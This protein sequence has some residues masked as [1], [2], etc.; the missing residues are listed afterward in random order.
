[1]PRA[2]APFI[3]RA[4]LGVATAILCSLSSAAGAQEANLPPGWVPSTPAGMIAEPSLLR[5]LASASESTIGGEP[6]DGFYVETGNMI[7]GE[8]W[9][10]AGPGYR[11]HLLDGAAVIDG[12]AAVSWNLYRTAQVSLQFPHLA[13]DRLSI[14]GQTM[15][16]DVLQVEYFGL[17]NDSNKSDQT[18][19]R[20]NN[21]DVVAF[22]RVQAN[23]WLSLDGRIGW[24]PRPDLSTATGPRV[25][26]PNTTDRF[27]EA[28]AP[29]IRTQPSFVHSDVAVVADTRDHAGHP[30]VGGLYRAS[31]AIYSDRGQGT[32]SFRRYE[33]EASQFVPLFT[34]KW[35]LALHGWEV[36]SDT[37]NGDV[38]PFYLMPSLGGKNTLRGYYDYRFHDND[39]QAFS[40]ESRWALFTHLDAAVFA[41][42]GKVAPDAADLDFHQLKRSYGVGLRAHNATSTLVRLDVGHS[43]EGW[44]FFVK[45]TDSFKRST[46]ASGR[47]AV[48]PFVP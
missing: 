9:I 46:P 6:R 23:R 27:S 10:S 3:T 7:T 38:V 36:F 22:G 11:R 41:D 37:S 8:G 18:A 45:V 17:G 32:Y 33:L 5:K 12:S 21:L 15:Y 4:L 35:I 2:R 14:G 1:M 47:T 16:Q 19:Y 30:T 20:F 13:H 48:V 42:V 34:R 25:N 29:G 43:V 24:I 26:F 40:A 28:T 39:M 31:A 44:R